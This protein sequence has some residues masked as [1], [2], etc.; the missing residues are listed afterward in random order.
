MHRGR[1]HYL[2]FA[3]TTLEVTT[4]PDLMGPLCYR[5]LDAL[6]WFGQ[7]VRETSD[8]ARFVKFITAIERIV[9]TNED[10]RTETVKKRAAAL[11]WEPDS[12]RKL[13]QLSERIGE[14][15]ALRSK[16][17]H[18]DISPF[19]E[20]IGVELY[21]CEA[22]ARRVLLRGLSFFQ[23][24]GLTVGNISQKGLRRHYKNYLQ[25]VHKLEKTGV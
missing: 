23:T 9:I 24:I 22:V 14:L 25:D 20:R 4:D 5:F 21:G 13:Y 10:D 3:G 12:E 17:V 16:L 18:G 8:A 19:D 15:Y 7:A 6:S 1:G 2:G 11:C